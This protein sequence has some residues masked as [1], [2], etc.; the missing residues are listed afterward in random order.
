MSAKKQIF[1]SKSKFKL[2]SGHG[3]ATL[4]YKDQQTGETIERKLNPGDVFE[5]AMGGGVRCENQ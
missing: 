4:S 1:K 5:A 3:S 2:K